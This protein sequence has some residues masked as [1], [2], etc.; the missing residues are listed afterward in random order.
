[1]AYFF[2]LFQNNKAFLDSA[3]FCF[4]LVAFVFVVCVLVDYAQS[5]P[6]R[7]KGANFY[8]PQ[9]DQSLIISLPHRSNSTN[10]NYAYVFTFKI[11]NTIFNRYLPLRLVP[12]DCIIDLYA[13]NIPISLSKVA[14]DVC[15]VETGIDLHEL[16]LNDNPDRALR[17]TIKDTL[18][19]NLGL[20]VIRA[21]ILDAQERTCILLLALYLLTFS[22]VRS[23]KQFRTTFYT[24]VVCTVFVASF[25]PHNYNFQDW[26]WWI[27]FMGNGLAVAFVALLG[28][29]WSPTQQ[30][31]KKIDALLQRILNISPKYFVAFCVLAFFVLTGA[32]SQLL[33]DGIP[34]VADTHVQYMQS[35]IFADGKLYALSHPLR[36][37]FDF[38]NAIND[39]K[40]YSGTFPGHPMLLAIGQLLGVPWL[41]NPLMGALTVWAVYLLANELAGRAA[42][43]VAACL[44]LISPMIVFMSS[45]YM[46]HAST[47]FF[48]TLF[49]YAYIKSLK[50]NDYR[51]YLLAGLSVGFAL[52]IRVQSTVPFALPIA[53]HAIWVFIRNPNRQ[54]NSIIMLLGFSVFLAFLLYFQ[55][56]TTGSPWVNGYDKFIPHYAGFHKEFLEKSRWLRISE[57][58][59]RGIIQLQ[60]KHTQ[61]FE[62]PSSPLWFLFILFLTKKKPT[63]TYLVISVIFGQFLGIVFLS[64][65]AGGPFIMAYMHECSAVLVVLITLGAQCLSGALRDKGSLFTSTHRATVTAIVL[66]C[67]IMAIP[68]KLVGLYNSYANNFWEGNWSYYY[69]VSHSVEKPALVFVSPY[70]AYRLLYFTQPPD[71]NSPIIFAQDLGYK[72][73]DL[74]EYYPGRAVYKLNWWSLQKIK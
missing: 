73:S 32:L 63:Y 12:D 53:L 24:W 25:W 70:T 46:N 35:K 50:T 27:N 44:M 33:F 2:K 16:K 42:G 31:Y 26:W 72:Y 45:E 68:S 29:L 55:Y 30:I 4:R 47:I 34:H 36:E 49:L 8:D 10:K 41:I 6:I 40:Y 21:S 14:R 69:M 20:Q 3:T 57:D 18:G 23:W 58:L 54:L 13:G 9:R 67:F 65:G 28:A 19:D 5:G 11:P 62:W 37:F 43:Y 1:M 71:N 17:V 38:Q 51:F 61:L 39:G 59:T 60:Q 66:L 22:Y 7:I 15:N 52:I 74:I 48:L 56:R 64:P